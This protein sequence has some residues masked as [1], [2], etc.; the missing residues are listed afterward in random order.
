MIETLKLVEYSSHE[1]DVE[2]EGVRLEPDLFTW[3]TNDNINETLAIS[4]CV[5]LPAVEHGAS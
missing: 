4:T 1:V 5:M 2:E 3:S